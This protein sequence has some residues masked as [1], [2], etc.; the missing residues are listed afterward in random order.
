FKDARTHSAANVRGPHSSFDR[1]Q[2]HRP[3]NRPCHAQKRPRQ[4]LRRR[5]HPQTQAAR[6]T[7]RRQKTHEADWAGGHPP[8]GVFGGAQGGRGGIA[9]SS[10][11]LLQSHNY[12][13][14]NPSAAE[15]AIDFAHGSSR[16]RE[17]SGLKI[18]A[19]FSAGPAEVR[20]RLPTA[21]LGVSVSSAKDGMVAMA[22]LP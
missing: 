15:A 17:K 22:A 12:L 16:L 1:R 5:H 3:R 8:G 2:D 14:C 18:K 11:R 13:Q 7:K 10:A 20:W 19:R 6:K 9:N 21:E 4:M